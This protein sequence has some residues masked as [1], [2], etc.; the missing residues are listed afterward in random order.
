VLA[1]GNAGSLG[2]LVTGLVAVGLAKGVY[3]ANIFASLYDVI[4]PK[5]RGTVAGTMNTVGWAGASLA[6]VVVGG[7]GDRNGLGSAIASIA[8]VYLA[9]GAVALAAARL[10]AS[11]AGPQ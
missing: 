5:I 7:L 9:A 6:P 11:T 8:G 4:D 3:E 2:V 10:A 1:I